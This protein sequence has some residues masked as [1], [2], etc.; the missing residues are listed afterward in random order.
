VLTDALP[1]NT[2]FVSA[3][4][5]GTLSAGVVTWN[6]GTLNAGAS[7]SVQLVARV[8]S[9]LAAGTLI[10]NSGPAIDSAQTTS[11]AGAAVTTTVTSAPELTL[12]LTDAPDPV[13]AGANLT[14]T[15]NYSNSGSASATGVIISAAVPADTTLVSATG[16]GTISGG[17]V[18]WSLGSLGVG[19]SSSVQMVVRVT[20]PLASG[21]L[22]TSGSTTIDCNETTPMSAAAITTTVASAP[23]LAVVKTDSPDP[24]QAGDYITYTLSYANNGNANATG[25]VITDTVPTN[26]SFV[27]ATNG[28]VRSGNTVTWN[29]GT[30]AASGA[31]SAQIVVKVTK[32]LANGTSIPAGAYNIDSAQTS[33]VAGPSITTAVASSPNLKARGKGKPDP[34]QAGTNL[35]YTLD[36]DNLGNAVATGTVLSATLPA[37]TTFVSATNGGVYGAGTVN[38]SLGNLSSDVTGSVDFVVHVNGSLPNGTLISLSSFTID[39]SQT[40]PVS[41]P[42][43]NTTVASTTILSL[44]IADDPDPVMSGADLTYTLTFGNSGNAPATGVQVQATLPTGTTFVSATDGGILTGNQ[45]TWIPGTL[46][47]GGTGLARMTVRVSSSAVS[48]SVI[49]ASG[50]TIDSNETSPVTAP[51]E[52]T[53][54][55]EPLAPVVTSAVEAQSDSIYFVRGAGQTVR[56]TGTSFQPG[57]ALNLSPGISIGATTVTGTTLATAPLTISGTA[58]LGP[59][60]LILTNPDGRAGSRPDALQVVKTPDANG[61][62]KIDGLDLNRLARAWNSASGEPEFFAAVDLDGDGYIGPD[63]LSIF[64]QY[65]GLKPPGCP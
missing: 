60:T 6:L 23:V 3:T 45:V 2:T 18:S 35:T 53:A 61:D 28:G 52:G 24:V 41:G 5:G 32:P 14:Y 64:T 1:A 16:G 36:Y 62:C 39:C 42:A 27:S 47:S 4:G 49:Q 58:S 15:L 40:P 10:S 33:P 63:E 65:F 19:A 46:L 43:V 20:S 12:T 8:T 51:T 55:T 59:R 21:T 44:A 56:V 48:G 54:V 31:G 17:S 11:V 50:W 25:T 30:L 38:W 37:N 29:L 26:T 22:V 9:P 57:A 7:S 34:T 13:Q